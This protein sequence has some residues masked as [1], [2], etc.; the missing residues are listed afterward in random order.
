MWTISHKIQLRVPR[1]RKQRSERQLSSV[2]YKPK[3]ARQSWRCKPLQHKWR[4]IKC[5]VNLIYYMRCEPNCYWM[6]IKIWVKT[7]IFTIC[8]SI[9]GPKLIW[10]NFNPFCGA[11]SGLIA[12]SFKY[13]NL[14]HT[15]INKHI[16][17]NTESRQNK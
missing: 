12:N 15:Y 16:K 4:K 7:D 5:P 3:M 13:L 9:R 6:K 2:D 1:G 14:V 10:Q 11:N 17:M 8:T